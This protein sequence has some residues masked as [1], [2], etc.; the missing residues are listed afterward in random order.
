MEISILEK[1]LNENKRSMRIR[2][3]YGGFFNKNFYK[4]MHKRRRLMKLKIIQRRR[5]VH[6]G[7]SFRSIVD[8]NEKINILSSYLVGTD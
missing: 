1:T 7:L 6:L 4:N 3:I 2:R 5:Y 8:Q